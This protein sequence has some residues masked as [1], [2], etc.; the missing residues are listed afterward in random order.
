[1]IIHFY[2]IANE[3]IYL[4][5]VQF[6]SISLNYSNIQFPRITGTKPEEKKHYTK[7]QQKTA[8]EI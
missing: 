6:C 2:K 8:M 1:M 3:L 5:F 4:K 7:E